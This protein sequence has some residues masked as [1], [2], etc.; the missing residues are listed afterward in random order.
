[1]ARKIVQI[2]AVAPGHAGPGA[3]GYYPAVI[4]L[5]DDGTVWCSGLV[6]E[7]GSFGMWEKLPAFPATDEEALQLLEKQNA[8]KE[9]PKLTLLERFAKVLGI[10]VSVELT[11][12]TPRR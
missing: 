10:R 9:Q 4:A 7:S 5:A 11:E 3:R 8:R 6:P 12:K 2:S 1:M